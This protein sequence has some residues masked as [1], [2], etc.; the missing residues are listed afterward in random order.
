MK[1]KVII[2]IIVAII[3]AGGLGIAGTSYYSNLKARNLEQTNATLKHEVAQQTQTQKDSS[4]A[5]QINLHIKDGAFE[6]A[7]KE[8]ASLTDPKTIQAL[9][10]KLN[11][12][13]E[14]AQNF[15]NSI[16]NALNAINK[17]GNIDAFS[18]AINGVNTDNLV[19]ADQNKLSKIKDALPSL[20]SLQEVQNLILARKFIQAK[21][22]FN[23]INENALINAGIL[24]QAKITKIQ[25]FV[26][27]GLNENKQII[28][29]VNSKIKEFNNK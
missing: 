12:Y 1:K 2:P 11:T 23:K 29:S 5:I 25:N 14:N 10:D 21:D 7:Q 17:S 4:D 26:N 9:N 8:I 27:A 20:K 6:L 24:T 16:K 13:K 18:K 22:E 28:D 15:N 19:V 3:V